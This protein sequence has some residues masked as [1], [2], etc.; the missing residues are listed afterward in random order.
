MEGWIKA[1]KSAR[2]RAPPDKHEDAWTRQINERL[3]FYHPDYTVGPGVSPDRGSKPSSLAGFT[4]DR[5]LR[6]RTIG[7]PHP[8]PKVVFSDLVSLA[9]SLQALK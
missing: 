7:F 2:L 9:S 4:A 6:N 3:T 8:A 5:E 1:Q